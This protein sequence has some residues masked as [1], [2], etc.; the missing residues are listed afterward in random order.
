MKMTA[1]GDDAIFGPLFRLNVPHV[2]SGIFGGL[3]LE[4]LLACRLVCW[5]WRRVN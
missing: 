3:D 1:D 2:L 5:Q 4:D